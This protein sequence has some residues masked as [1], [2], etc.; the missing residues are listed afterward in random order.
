MLRKKRTVKNRPEQELQKSCVIWLEMQRRVGK[1]T[2]FHVPNGGKRSKREA[3]ILKGLGVRAGVPDLVIGF[4]GG[5][6]LYVELK[7]PTGS[8]VS[9]AQKEFH[10]ELTRMGFV[11]NIVRTLDQLMNAVKEGNRI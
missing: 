2:Y 4:P 7:A 9:Q 3:W 1:L 6:T 5:R 10:E 8:S 11:V